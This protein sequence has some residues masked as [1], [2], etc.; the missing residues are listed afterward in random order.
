MAMAVP[1]QHSGGVEESQH[2]ALQGFR[3]KG[4]FDPTAST[5]QPFNNWQQGGSQGSCLAY[6]LHPCLCLL[7]GS[8]FPFLGCRMT[9]NHLKLLRHAIEAYAPCDAHR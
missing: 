8:R 7:F 1:W 9:F 2:L 3:A 5:S 6:L 4:P